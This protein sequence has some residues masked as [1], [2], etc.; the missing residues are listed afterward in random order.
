M[1]K[2]I[3]ATDRDL[4]NTNPASLIDWLD[5]SLYLTIQ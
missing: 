3:N 1:I 5:N 4:A 2:P